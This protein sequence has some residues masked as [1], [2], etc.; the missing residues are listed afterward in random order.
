MNYEMFLK[1]YW[2]YFLEL[3]ENLLIIQRYVNFEQ[4]NWKVYSNE[5]IKLLEVI[6]SEIDVIAKDI[7]VFKNKDLKKKDIN[8][9]A[10]WGYEI[11]KLIPDIDLKEIKFNYENIITPWKD[12]KHEKNICKD[13][14]IRMKLVHGKKNPEW[15]IAY[16]RVKHER[17]TYTVNGYNYERANLEN[18]INALGGLYI[19]EKYFLEELKNDNEI[20]YKNSKLYRG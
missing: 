6:G 18:V 11:Q 9:I 15:W 5:F 7:V 12:W 3:E 1:S 4:N 20:N 14:M 19:L 8:G 13:G 16:N 17:T 10:K 2:N